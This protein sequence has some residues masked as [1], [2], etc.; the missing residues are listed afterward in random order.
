VYRFQG[1]FEARPQDISS[2]YYQRRIER[3]GFAGSVEAAGERGPYAWTL[4]VERGVQDEHQYALGEADPPRDAWETD[5]WTAGGAVRLGAAGADDQVVVS[6]RYTTL[7]GQATRG[8]LPDTLTFVS[9]ESLLDAT[10]EAS[11]ALG[12]R[13]VLTARATLNREDRTR[14]DH[15]ARVGTDIQGW[16]TG[17]GAGLVVRASDRMEFGAAGAAVAYR[18]GG[19]IPRP[20]LLGPVYGSYVSPELAL[21]A[22]DGTAMAAGVSVLWRG[23]PTG[24]L[25]AGARYGRLEPAGGTVTLTEAPSGRRT[26]WVVEVGVLLGR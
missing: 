16:A 6:V 18:A 21:A 15:L 8:D 10:A 2:G 17:F 19:G 13:L 7:A 14:S 22:S 3:D 20:D 4:F 11:K 5:A 12:D 24:A 26:T 1:Y 25:L 9:D 23:L